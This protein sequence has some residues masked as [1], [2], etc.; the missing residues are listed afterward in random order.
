MKIFLYSAL[1]A[2]L[3]VAP[4]LAQTDVTPQSMA[5]R[6]ADVAGQIKQDLSALTR[7]AT[8]E[9][10]YFSVYPYIYGARYGYF[11][12]FDWAKQLNRLLQESAI[13]IESVRVQGSSQTDARAVVEYKIIP[14]KIDDD[15]QRK[16]WSGVHQE[17]VDLKF[18]ANP[19]GGSHAVWRIVPPPTAPAEM[20]SSEFIAKHDVL[21]AN[22]AYGF[23]QTQ[24]P[25][26]KATPAERSMENLRKLGLC[27]AAFA[28]DY[29]DAYVFGAPYYRE[30]LA[31]Y[32]RNSTVFVAPELFLVPNTNEIY[33]FN[34][35]LSGLKTDEIKKPAQTILFYEGQN[36]TPVFRYDGKAAIGFADGH[37]ALITPDE[38]KSLVWKP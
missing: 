34:G 5:A 36:E 28:Q 30:A 10:G 27:A 9:D 23:A 18:G 20:T 2:T 29:D 32:M 4:A 14:P 21:L 19:S 11:G 15:E 12:A 37:V 16:F 31:P 17:T 35:N 13:Q 33:S 38:A 7:A 26:I 8:Q 25:K 24:M 1:A 3:R 22:I 6:P